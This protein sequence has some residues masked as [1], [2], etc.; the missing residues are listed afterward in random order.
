MNLCYNS[1]NQY[2]TSIKLFFFFFLGFLTEKIDGSTTGSLKQALRL[3]LSVKLCLPAQYCRHEV[4]L[5]F[6]TMAAAARRPM[7]SQASWPVS[8]QGSL[9]VNFG[10]NLKKIQYTVHTFSLFVFYTNTQIE[11]LAYKCNVS[12]VCCL[13]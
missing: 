12:Q 13:Q 6:E 3:Y 9:E 11:F 10:L 7:A 4:F 2:F 8:Q 1:K 5:R